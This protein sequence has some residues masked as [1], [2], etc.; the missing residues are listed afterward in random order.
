[1]RLFDLVDI[2][3]G[4]AP[5]TAYIVEHIDGGEPSLEECEAGIEAIRRLEKRG[6]LRVIL[7]EG[8]KDPELSCPSCGGNALATRDGAFK[9]IDFQNF[10]LINYDRFLKGLVHMATKDSHFG[11]C[12][13]VRGGRYLYQAIP[14]VNVT[15]KRDTQLRIANLRELMD[16]AGVSVVERLVLDIGCNIGAM[17]AEYLKSGAKWCIGWDKAHVAVHT[18]QVLLALGCTRFS[19]L[20]GDL[21]PERPIYADI[22]DFLRA[23][24]PGCVISY[25]AVRGHLGWIDALQRIPWAFMIYEGHEGESLED[26]NRHVVE[27]N[28]LVPVRIAEVRSYTD[29]DSSARLIALLMRVSTHSNSQ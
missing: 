24:L 4:P 29:G 28:A 25:L 16:Y 10:R 2:R 18:N 17:M 22:P 11:D 8:F 12:S 3:C 26:F 7:P 14:S 27:L 15:S 1:M 21:H 20:A 23:S 6:L 19:V 9:Y 13:I 5:W